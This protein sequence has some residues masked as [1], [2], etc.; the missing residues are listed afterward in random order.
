MKKQ[1]VFI[2][3][4]HCSK[5]LGIGRQYFGKKERCPRCGGVITVSRDLLVGLANKGKGDNEDIVYDT[6]PGAV[7][8]VIK[9]RGVGI[10][11]FQTSRI[12]DQ[13]N[14]QELGEELADLYKKYDLRKVVLN[15]KGVDYMSSAVLGKL[16]QLRKMLASAGGELY[17][18][19]ISPAIFEI[20]EIMRFDELFNI[21]SDEDEAVI[22][23]MD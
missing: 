12:L 21:A 13:T 3:C 6:G 20:F 7:L 1:S 22:E 10:A 18:C 16:V 9:Q 11:R 8:K 17:L 15:F 4:P 14:V 23:L 2:E 19:N 5:R